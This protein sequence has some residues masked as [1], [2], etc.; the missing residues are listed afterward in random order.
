M[1]S[2]TPVIG[3]ARR[4]RLGAATLVFAVALAPLVTGCADER[5][6]EQQ[7]EAARR[8]CASLRERVT[9][10]A[11]ADPDLLDAV[12]AADPKADPL[13]PAAFRDDPAAW[14]A[15]LE[16][17]IAEAGDRLG[18]ADGPVGTSGASRLVGTCQDL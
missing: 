16:A 2:R 9:A 4:R 13:G 14:Y 10:R 15:A 3:A 7:L 1:A 12:R 11:L 18:P 5:L 6:D 17:A 8:T